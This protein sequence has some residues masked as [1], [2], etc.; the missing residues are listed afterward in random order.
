MMMFNSIYHQLCD[1]S[2][3]VGLRDRM[4]CP[5]CESVGTWKAHGGWID[6]ILGDK[7]PVRRW[8]CKW[9]GMY[10][11]PEGEVQ[12]RPGKKAWSLE[13]EES[14]TPM[15]IASQ[16]KTCWPWIG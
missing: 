10:K 2:R 3:L 14:L 4:R 15:E 8:L 13:E 6:R 16:M 1:F 11:G 12:A 9:C 5:Y 7:R